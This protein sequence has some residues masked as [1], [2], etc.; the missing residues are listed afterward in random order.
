[1]FIR[2]WVA[3]LLVALSYSVLAQE[4]PDW[5]YNTSTSSVQLEAVGSGSSLRAAKSAA[6]AEIIAQVSQSVSVK[7]LSVLEKRQDQTSQ[8]FKQSMSTQTL[9]ID[10]ND[11]AVG[12]QFF[13]KSSGTLYVKA[14]IKKVELIRFLEDELTPLNE[15]TFPEYSSSANQVLW[16]LKYK[17][18]NEYGLRVERALNALGAGKPNS[19]KRLLDN[20]S[21][22]ANVW[23]NYGVRVI[24]DSS[25]QSLSGV[26]TQHIPTATEAT[27]WLQ[28]KPSFKIRQ[29]HNTY[30]QKLDLSIELTQPRSP[31][32]T[33]R[34]KNI[35][36]I[37]SGESE[38]QAKEN[39]LQQVHTILDTPIQNW[40]FEK[41]SEL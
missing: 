7:S 30:Q 36:V 11:V 15:L 2:S 3:I 34:Q 29:Q 39:A 37:G 12:K 9:A 32:K 17:A 13:D 25:L 23:Q 24:A 22:V 16:S 20:L 8:R 1:M 5:I 4:P 33:Y 40:F 26:I 28:L 6:V 19:K 31:F 18:S 35:S 21:A 27:L 10:I 14:R 38:S 41:G